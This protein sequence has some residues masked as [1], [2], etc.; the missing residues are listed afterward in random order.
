MSHDTFKICPRNFIDEI[1]PW[2]PHTYYRIR[3]GKNIRTNYD[4]EVSN[5]KEV[6]EDSCMICDKYKINRTEILLD[7]YNCKPR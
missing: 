2:S 6:R 5:F 4:H 7:I 3:A 1:G